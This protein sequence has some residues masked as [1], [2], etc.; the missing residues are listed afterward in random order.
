MLDIKFIRE[1][2]DFIK[3]AA[4]KKRISFDVDSL[5]EVDDK[6]KTI[7]ASIEAKKAEQNKCSLFIANPQ[8]LGSAYQKQELI[9]KM[10][11][12]K[13]EMKVEEEQLGEVMKVWHDLMLQVPNIPDMSVPEGASEND[14]QEIRTWGEVP[15]F[16][17]PIK[18]HIEI[19]EEHGL[20]DFVSIRDTSTSGTCTVASTTLSGSDQ[21]IMATRRALVR[22]A[23]RSV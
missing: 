20:A 4:R 21:N 2:K 22:C 14:N 6:R 16:S 10:T 13:N 8:H 19:C 11:I 9:E 18:N 5:V 15:T 1:H 17:F 3:E 23:S 7:L 12:L